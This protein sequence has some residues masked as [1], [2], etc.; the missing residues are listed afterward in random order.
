MLIE[1]V[2]TGVNYADVIVRMGLYR[3]GIELIGWPITQGFE[4]SR[5]ILEVGKHVTDLA[6][7]DEVVGLTLFNG[8]ASHMVGLAENPA[9]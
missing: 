5:R 6:V 2:A 1:V 9:I 4:V 8:Y 7:V 3:S